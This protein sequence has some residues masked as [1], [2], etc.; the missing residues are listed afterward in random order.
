MDYL[1][2]TVIDNR[3]EILEKVGTGGMATVYKAKCKVLDRFVAIKIL[4]DSLKNDA[5]VVKK[6]NT[7]SR[8]AARLSHPN[9]VQVYDVWKQV[10]LIT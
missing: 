5:D 4:K 1:I 2:G 6:F 10:S 8:A 9:I 7:E 3:Y